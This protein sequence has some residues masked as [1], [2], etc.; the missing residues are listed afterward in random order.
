MLDS[1]GY[2]VSEAVTALGPPEPD[3]PNLA[4][5]GDQLQLDDKSLNDAPTR[6]PDRATGTKEGSKHTHGR[7]KRARGLVHSTQCDTIAMGSQSCMARG[8]SRVRPASSS[9][10]R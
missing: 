5:M 8:R 9:E 6:A 2:S 4:T 1:R 7:A 3:R 10:S